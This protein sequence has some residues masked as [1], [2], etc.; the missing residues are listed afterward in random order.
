MKIKLV[1][2]DGVF[3]ADDVSAYAILNVLYPNNELIRTRKY[4]EFN[5]SIK[6]IIFDVGL[7]YDPEKNKF[8]HHQRGFNL[9]FEGSSVTPMSSVGLIYKHFGR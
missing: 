7:I 1:T 3:H 5:K 4:N 8:D 6:S 9:Q 2:H